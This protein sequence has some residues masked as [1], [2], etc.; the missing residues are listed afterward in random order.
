MDYLKD[1]VIHFVGL[2]VG[3]HQF[4]FEV[5]DLFFE[6]FEYSQL[7]HGK[8]KVVVDLDKQERMLV[9][10]FRMDGAVEVVCDRC[11][12]EFMLP[13]SGTEHLIVK[14][15]EGYTEESDDM[16]TIPSTEYKVD[17]APFIYEYIHL[18][19]PVK[20]VHPDDAD[21]KTTCNADTL[22]ILEKLTVHTDTDPR[23]DILNNL[24]TE[25]QENEENE[26]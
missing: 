9:F 21:G 4:E 12:D 14:Y 24:K 19:L 23:W 15:G 16:I 20:I 5:N 13:L 10:S 18:L 25:D 6:Q 3:N 7:Q 11:A 22:Q 8:V 17:L 2:S 26:K 1:F